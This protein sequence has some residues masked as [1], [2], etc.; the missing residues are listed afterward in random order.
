MPPAAEINPSAAEAAFKSMRR[1]PEAGDTQLTSE[2]NSLMASLDDAVKPKE[3]AERYP[4][5]VNRSAREWRT[6]AALD[7]YF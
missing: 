2:G 5:I 6:P 4:R 3:L 1:T 7:R